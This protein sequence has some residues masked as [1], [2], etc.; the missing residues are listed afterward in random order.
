MLG[1]N[2]IQLIKN[3]YRDI[4]RNC[5]PRLSI[6][7]T[8][9][10]CFLYASSLHHP[11]SFFYCVSSNGF[12]P[13][14]S[15]PLILFLSTSSF[16]PRLNAWCCSFYLALGSDQSISLPPYIFLSIHHC[17]IFFYFHTLAF[18]SCILVCIYKL[19]MCI[20]ASLFLV[21][22]YL[23]SAS[24]LLSANLTASEWI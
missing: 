10:F 15:F 23:L 22:L 24:H 4:F 2:V 12:L 20:L 13:S 14:H 16:W 17:L 18:H 3:G 1:G 21:F 6:A 19:A 8:R 5:L 7:K 9:H 11:C